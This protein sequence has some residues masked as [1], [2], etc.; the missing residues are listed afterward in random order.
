[1]AHDPLAS[2]SPDLVQRLGRVKLLALDVDGVLTDGQLIFHADGTE[3][4]AFNT[5]DGHGIKL[6]RRAGIDVALITGRSSPMVSQRAKALG[7]QHVQQGVERKLPALASLCAELSLSLEEVAYCGDDLP[8]L[9]CIDRCGV[10]ISVPG[11]PFYIRERARWVTERCG[12]H[13]AVREITDTLLAAQGRLDG[14][15][16]SYLKDGPLI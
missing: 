1:M 12:G 3:L 7:I 6:A 11:A 16:N 13:G 5:L 8:D 9:P 10:G 2:L 14:V 4:K 15:V